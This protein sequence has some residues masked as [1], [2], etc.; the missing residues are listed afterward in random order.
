MVEKSRASV[1]SL[2][3]SVFSVSG[4]SLSAFQFQI[5]GFRLSRFGMRGFSMRGFSLPGFSLPGFGLPGFGLP[6][7]SRL[8][9][10]GHVAAQVAG[11]E[12]GP[13]ALRTGSSISKRAPPCSRLSAEMRP[14]ADSTM[15]RVMA[16]P[17]P[18]W[19]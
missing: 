6:G 3:L 10:T 5:A 16:R 8:S 9:P 4:F 7:F 1:F 12:A 15:E 13:S 18:R 17:R 14:P 2:G 19:L 11:G